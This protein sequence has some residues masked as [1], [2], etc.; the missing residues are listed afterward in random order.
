MLGEAE[1]LLK[2]CTEMLESIDEM[3]EV[4][5][6]TQMLGWTCHGLTPLLQSILL[7]GP[8]TRQIDGFDGAQERL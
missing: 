2:K 7:A 3:A 1:A 5:C 4:R 8:C 6:C